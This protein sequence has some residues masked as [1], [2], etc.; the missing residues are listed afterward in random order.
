MSAR[1]IGVHCILEAQEMLE[2]LYL[3]NLTFHLI[4]CGYTEKQTFIT[5]CMCSLHENMQ[6]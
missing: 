1:Q 5:F 3:Q 2:I 6:K 4:V